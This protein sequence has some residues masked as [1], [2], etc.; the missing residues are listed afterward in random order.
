[1]Q[2]E[3][4]EGNQK[5]ETRRNFFL[6]SESRMCPVSTSSSNRERRNKNWRQIDSSKNPFIPSSFRIF[7]ILSDALTYY[8]TFQL[9]KKY[10]QTPRTIPSSPPSNSDTYQRNEQRRWRVYTALK[11]SRSNL[12]FNCASLVAVQLNDSNPTNN[13]K[14]LVAR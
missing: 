14:H 4:A 7:S 6:A 2:K 1:M 13:N 12:S 11:A 10:Q 5:Q 9:W 8:H 3:A